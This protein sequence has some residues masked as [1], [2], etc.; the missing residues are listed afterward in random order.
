MDTSNN[1][2]TNMYSQQKQDEATAGNVE[3]DPTDPDLWSHRLDMA[4][5][6]PTHPSQYTDPNNNQFY[7]DSKLAENW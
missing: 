5:T 2:L 7:H 1:L 3:Y 4:H 6:V